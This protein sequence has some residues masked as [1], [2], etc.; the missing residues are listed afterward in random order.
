MVLV[1]YGLVILIGL[2]WLGYSLAVYCK[3]KVPHIIT[4]QSRIPVILENLNITPQTVIYDLG[5]GK[6]D[7]LFA[8]EKYSPAELVGFELSPLLAWWGQ[9]KA[10]L[11]HSKVEIKRKDFFKADISRADVI[12]LFLVQA[13]VNK[14][15]EKLRNEVKPGA[16]IVCLGDKV[17]G[18]KLKKIIEENIRGEKNVKIYFYKVP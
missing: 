4:P 3:T 13:V 15:T 2:M 7:F 6:G 11:R 10:K 12:Y 17:S 14:L 16:T 8:I 18:F 9:L 1:L 5:C